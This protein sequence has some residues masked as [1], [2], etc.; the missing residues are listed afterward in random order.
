MALTMT[1]PRLIAIFE[2]HGSEVPSFYGRLYW[3][4]KINGHARWNIDAKI[5]YRASIDAAVARGDMGNGKM[6]VEECGRDCDGVEYRGRLHVIWAT[7]S[8]YLALQY[9][10]G[11]WA[12]GPFSLYIIPLDEPTPEYHSHDTFAEAAGY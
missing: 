7:R 12:D 3:L 9:R 8:S 4:N 6:R 2:E 10:I 1:H 5:N 11:E